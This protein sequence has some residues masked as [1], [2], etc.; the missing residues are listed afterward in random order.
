MCNEAN[1]SGQDIQDEAKSG[2]WEERKEKRE[3]IVKKRSFTEL[4]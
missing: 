4:P 3:I 2:L 1:N